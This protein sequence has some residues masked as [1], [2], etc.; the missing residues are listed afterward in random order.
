MNVAGWTEIG[1]FVVVLTALTPV[2]GAYLARVFEG[3]ALVLDRV[4]GPVERASYRLIGTRA[5]QEQDWKGY[6]R[7]VLAFS[8]IGFLALYLILRTQGIH[9]FNPAGLSSP[10]WDV[11]LNT[12]TSFV[13]NTNWQFYG[14]E[15]TMTY[16]SQMA[17]LAVQNFLSAAV[18]IAVVAAV[19]RGFARRGTDR[20]G[21]FWV[22]LT[23]TTLYILLP[24][25]VVGALFL[26]SQGAIQ[27]LDSYTS[28]GTIAGA[29]QTLAVGPVASQ[30]I[31]KELGT[32][33]G[34]FFNVNAAM[35][36]ENPSAITNFFLML[37]ILLIPAGLTSAFGR[38]VGNRRQGWTIFAAMLALFVVATAIV[39]GAESRLRQ[40]CTPPASAARTSRA[41]RFASGLGPPHFSPPSRR[42]LPVGP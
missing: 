23:R 41:R 26:V 5:E 25:S 14:G 30:E 42:S 18:G 12:T 17:G 1:V 10:P 22:D 33:G 9:P 27:T 16:F 34:G 31:I 37:M 20:L 38:M 19:I 15:T 32:N 11:S 7:A 3:D 13:T 36:F 35:P 39:Y 6:V 21:N 24:I 4:L 8:F 28:F 2:V 40:L 29:Q